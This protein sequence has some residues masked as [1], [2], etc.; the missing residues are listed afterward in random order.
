MPQLSGDREVVI[1]FQYQHFPF[2]RGFLTG[3]NDQAYS[4]TCDLEI[5]GIPFTGV[6]L[7]HPSDNFCKETGRKLALQRALDAAWRVL[8][9]ED[10]T[11][12]WSAYFQRDLGRA[13]EAGEQQ[14]DD[15]KEVAR[16]QGR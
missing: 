4:T 5:D 16:G 14:A 8:A 12:I 10:R 9:K 11:R 6:A 3:E 1:Q 13:C 2:H 15:E 7:C